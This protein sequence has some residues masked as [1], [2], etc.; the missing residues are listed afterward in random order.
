MDDVSAHATTIL[1]LSTLLYDAKHVLA[2]KALVHL[3]VAGDRW[4]ML[5]DSRP[6]QVDLETSC[7]LV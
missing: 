5:A 1:D 7:E 3:L 6:W 4:S 2:R